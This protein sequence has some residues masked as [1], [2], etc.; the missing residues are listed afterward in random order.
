MILLELEWDLVDSRLFLQMSK[1][2]LFKKMTKS[3]SLIH[4]LN[5]F[6]RKVLLMI[7]ILKIRKRFNPDHMI[8]QDIKDRIDIIHNKL[9]GKNRHPNI[10]K[11]QWGLQ[12]Q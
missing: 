10:I 11:T 8:M 7:Y 4:Y 6:K 9:M 2:I 5:L 12:I 3:I 1:I